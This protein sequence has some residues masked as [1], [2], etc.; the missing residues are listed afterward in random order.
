MQFVCTLGTADG[1]VI[2][3]VHEGSSESSLRLELE[4]RGF[5]VLKMRPRGGLS[6]LSRLSLPGLGARRRRIPDRDLLLFNQELAALLRSGLPVLQALGL[7]LER[8]RD[9]V[10]REMLEDVHREVRDGSDLSTAFEKHGD[11]LPPL[12]APT[13]KAGERSGEL[14]GVIRRFVRYM[15]LVT[16]A[17]RKVV[18]ALVYPAVLIGL[19]GF[20]IAVMTVYV[21]PKFTEFFSA[22]RADLPLLT[23]MTL[24]FSRFMSSYWWAVASAI[25]L[26]VFVFRSWSATAAGSRFTD[27]LKLRWPILGQ[28]FRKLALSEFARSLATLLA[29]GIPVLP[30]L[31]NSVGAVSNAHIRSVLQPMI[32]KVREGG[33]LYAALEATRECPDIVVEMAKVGEE[34]G[35]LDEMLN[36]ASDFLDD[37][38]ETQMSRLLVLVE[39]IMLVLMGLIVATLLVAVYLPLFS[40]LSDVGPR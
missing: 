36:N 9:Q 19:S 32:S 5:D 29:G 30:A 25:A 23:R 13:L 2:Q 33:A 1:A 6:L 20:L 14:E 11:V 12:Y 37:E 7:M 31:E 8:Q 34:T 10:F 26:S 4:R 39:P 21:V 22:L 3:Q 28:I 18:S 35:S 16:E 38:V 27:R 24:A 17:R 40:M 15:Q